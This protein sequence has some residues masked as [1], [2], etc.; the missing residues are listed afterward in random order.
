MVGFLVVV[1]GFLLVAASI[2]SV[3]V[4]NRRL[5][6]CADRV[7][8][9]ASGA[10][11]EEA[12]YTQSRITSTS[13]LAQARAEVV[14][15]RLDTTTCRIGNGVSLVSVEVHD[16]HVTV[17]MQA[18]ASVPLVPAFLGRVAEPT[19]TVQSSAQTY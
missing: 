3:H 17:R 10:T 11:D 7:A 2:T 15:K 5:M 16:D 4:Q 12:L 18:Q 6:T 8:A 19:L 14:L 9:A 13:E 1:L